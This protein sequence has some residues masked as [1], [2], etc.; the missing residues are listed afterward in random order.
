MSLEVEKLFD[1]NIS[2]TDTDEDVDMDTE[3]L[4]L[5]FQIWTKELIFTCLFIYLL[6]NM[7]KK[8]ECM[9]K[10]IINDPIVFSFV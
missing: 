1:T 6:P 5:I 3:Y 9:C 8:I 7:R 4:F 2:D 10:Y